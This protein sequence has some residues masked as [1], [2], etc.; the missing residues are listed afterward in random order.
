[1]SG[2]DNEDSRFPSS[3]PG[4]KAE[5][6][7]GFFFLASDTNPDKSGERFASAGALYI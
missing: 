5:K 3:S 4:A 7:P 6:V 1:M 2:Y